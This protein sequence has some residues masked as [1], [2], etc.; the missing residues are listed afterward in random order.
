MTLDELLGRGGATSFFTNLDDARAFV[1][2]TINDN[3]RLVPSEKQ[4]LLIIEEEAVEF[5]FAPLPFGV[6]YVCAPKDNIGPV[7][8]SNQQFMNEC[9][10]NYYLYLQNQFPLITDD[11]RFLSIYDAAVDG[12]EAVNTSVSKPSDL[13]N[14]NRNAYIIGAVLLGFLLLSR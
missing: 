5:V 7:N 9:I 2:G 14:P 11:Q 1:Q 10:Q 3:P 12:V 6:G 13:L 8:L 4:R